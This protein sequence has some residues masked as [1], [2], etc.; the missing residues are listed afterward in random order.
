MS[1]T[2][3]TLL[4]LASAFLAPALAAPTHPTNTTLA[5]RHAPS[6]HTWPAFTFCDSSAPTGAKCYRDIS[7]VGCY[8]F[9][10]AAFFPIVIFD[11]KLRCTVY[12]TTGC[13]EHA[14]KK[15]N[16]VVHGVEGRFDASTDARAKEHGVESVGSLI[17]S[18]VS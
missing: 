12:G 16:R 15:R 18:K 9:R 6:P 3:L 13:M 7:T 2:P 10:A 14:G 4:A 1:P 17:C 5:A 11:P 8:S